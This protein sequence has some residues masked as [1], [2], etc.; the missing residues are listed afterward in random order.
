M[1]RILFIT[2]LLFFLFISLVS[3]IWAN[4]NRQFL[5]VP[6]FEDLPLMQDLEEGKFETSFFDSPDGRIVE[7]TV[8]VSASA[9]DIKRFYHLTLPQL[10]W[11]KF[12][13]NYFLREKEILSL[14]IEKVGESGL[15]SVK[16]FLSPQNQE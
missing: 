1:I 2:T 16:F 13:K 6:G 10:G 8:I 15:I 5:F 14:Q 12:K 9:K 7:S 4:E 11:A 3:G